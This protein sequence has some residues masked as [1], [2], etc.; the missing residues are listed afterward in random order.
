M[1][2]VKRDFETSHNQHKLIM[3]HIDHSHERDALAATLRAL[4]QALMQMHAELAALRAEVQRAR[5]QLKSERAQAND[6]A[7][8]LEE[9]EL[10]LRDLRGQPAVATDPLPAHMIASVAERCVVLEEQALRQLIRVDELAAEC[11][12]AERALVERERAWAVREAQLNSEC[13]RIRALLQR[14]SDSAPT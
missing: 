8:E 13:E 5:S 7:W 1:F 10:R 4:E 2:V 6:L 3:S 11:A 14:T 12:A 9:L